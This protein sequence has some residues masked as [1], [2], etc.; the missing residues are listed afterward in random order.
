MLVELWNRFKTKRSFL[1]PKNWGS[2]QL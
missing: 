1:Q 2:E